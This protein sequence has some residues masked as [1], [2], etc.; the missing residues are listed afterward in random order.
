MV[1][2]QGFVPFRAPKNQQLKEAEATEKQDEIYSWFGPRMKAVTSKIP[3]GARSFRIEFRVTGG[4][5]NC[6][7]VCNYIR[8][9]IASKGFKIKEVT[10]KV[11]VEIHPDK[12]PVLNAWY[13]AQRLL[14]STTVPREA[15]DACGRSLA[16]LASESGEEMGKWD[17]V[18]GAWKWDH[19][20]CA[21]IN[22][23][24]RNHPVA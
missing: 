14:E 4:K 23:D 11:S 17:K 9:Q 22:F 16:I 12:R 19:T 13:S 8:S 1:R 5:D 2:V 20:A 18:A 21:N 7:S 15:W 6:E 10:P 24:S 3:P